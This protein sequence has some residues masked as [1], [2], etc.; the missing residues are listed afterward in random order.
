MKNAIAHRWKIQTTKIYSSFNP[1]RFCWIP[2][3]GQ[4]YATYLPER[5]AFGNILELHFLQIVMVVNW[6]CRGYNSVLPRIPVNTLCVNF[7]NYQ[8]TVFNNQTIN[9]LHIAKRIYNCWGYAI[10]KNLLIREWREL[11]YENTHKKY[12]VN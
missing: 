7:Q 3:T 8:N 6:Y 4:K 2:H 10:T 11:N 9:N 12:D 1:N 5:T